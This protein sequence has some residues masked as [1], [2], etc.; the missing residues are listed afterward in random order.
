MLE[1]A[2]DGTPVGYCSFAASSYEVLLSPASVVPFYDLRP[3]TSD[4]I[5]ALDPRAA[6]ASVMADF[7]QMGYPLDPSL[8]GAD[9]G[10][11]TSDP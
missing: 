9:S 4:M 1:V 6:I 10:S 11:R 2:L 5:T 8:G 7:A 3:A